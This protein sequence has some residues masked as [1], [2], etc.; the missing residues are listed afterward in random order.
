MLG[1]I[2]GWDCNCMEQ[3]PSC[4]ADS[5]QLVRKFFAFYGTRRFITTFTTTRHLPL[6]LL[7]LIQSIPSHPGFSRFFLIIIFPSTPRFSKLFFS[8]FP[9]KPCCAFFIVT[10]TCHMPNPS[11]PPVC[12]HTVSSQ[13]YK[14]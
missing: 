8:G 11:H 7:N 13:G 10:H 5:F 6:S 9:A 14:C 2:R 12:R 1:R 3:S 4:E